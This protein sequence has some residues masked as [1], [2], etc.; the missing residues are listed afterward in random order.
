MFI[1]ADADVTLDQFGD[2]LYPP[3]P[4]ELLFDVHAFAQILDTPLL[5]IQFF[6]FF[7]LS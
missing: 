3:F 1:E 5:L 2:A 6:L 7:I 4:E